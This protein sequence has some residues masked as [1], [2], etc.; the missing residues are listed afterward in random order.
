MPVA[1]LLVPTPEI[2]AIISRNGSATE[3]RQAMRTA[4]T[5][6]MRDRA[7]MLVAAGA[8]TEQEIARVIGTDDEESETGAHARQTVLVA[9]DDPVT[10]TLVRLL[11]ERDGYAVVEASTGRIAVDLTAS[12]GPELIV[13]DLNMP[14]MDGYEAIQAIRRI[15]S[16]A[17]TPIVVV[18]AEDGAETE[19]KVLA[20][21]ADDYIVKPF[22]P[23]VLTARIKAVFG[24][25][26]LAA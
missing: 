25:Q 23:T 5:R 7:Q 1:E 4:E 22:E 20:L 21:G 12:K 9:D 14:Q 15:P 17:K 8:T 10:R 3:L 26:R 11:L 6:T 24:R 2:R 19:R 16:A 13:M 18:T